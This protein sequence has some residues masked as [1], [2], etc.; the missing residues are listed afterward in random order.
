MHA[1]AGYMPT[2]PSQPWVWGVCAPSLFQ[3]IRATMPLVKG[4]PSHAGAFLRCG[5]CSGLAG[6]VTGDAQAFR[7]P[8]EAYNRGDYA[9]VAVISSLMFLAVR[10]ACYLSRPARGVKG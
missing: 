3:A 8:R 2:L 4:E 5:P 9:C 6:G 10:D 1:G 7:T